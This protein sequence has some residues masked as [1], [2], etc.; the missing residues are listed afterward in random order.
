MHNRHVIGM[1]DLFLVLLLHSVVVTVENRVAEE[2]CFED[3][4]PDRQALLGLARESVR[5][6]KFV[7]E[8]VWAVI[9]NLDAEHCRDRAQSV[10]EVFPPRELV[11]VAVPVQIFSKRL[12]CES[13]LSGVVH[14]LFSF[15]SWGFSS[16]FH[17][18]ALL[19]G[20]REKRSG[21]VGF[22][23]L[24]TRGLSRRHR[25]SQRH[26]RRSDLLPRRKGY[27]RSRL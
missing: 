16:I 19:R 10:T 4:V 8:T 1:K 11:L 18:N 5:A 20:Q 26:G 25:R 12:D 24:C 14:C 3:F 13:F 9:V 22:R 21:E 17:A 6:E 27:L 15:L 2:F 7:H 23:L